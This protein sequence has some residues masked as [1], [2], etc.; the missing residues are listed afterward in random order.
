MFSLRSYE[1]CNSVA[2]VLEFLES[3]ESCVILGGNHWLRQGCRVFDKGLDLSELEHYQE[4]QELPDGSLKVGAGVSY[5]ELEDHP[6]VQSWLSGVLSYA[7]KGIVGRQLRNT[8]KLGASIYSRFAFS[9]S[10]PVLLAA[11]VKLELARRGEISLAEF[12]NLP[13]SQLKK[14]FLLS[15]TLAKKEG[16]ASYQAMRV[17]ANDFPLLCAALVYDERGF[18]CTFGARPGLAQRADALSAYLD[19]RLVR[20]AELISRAQFYEL[21][22]PQFEKSLMSA[23]QEDVSFGSSAGADK[24]YRLSLASRMLPELIEKLIEFKEEGKSYA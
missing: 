9:D 15:C 8:A 3:Q 19:T 20:E 6:W 5:G 24:N 13:A 23:L 16:Y 2:Q 7:L 4:L 1:R 14:D 18:S 12:L 22:T 10:L 11:D 17:T 21:N